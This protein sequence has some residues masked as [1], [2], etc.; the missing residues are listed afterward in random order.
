MKVA[1]RRGLSTSSA[2]WQRDRF[3]ADMLSAEELAES[4][5]SDAGSLRAV[6]SSEPAAPAVKNAR[7]VAVG[8]A[9]KSNVAQPIIGTT[10]MAAKVRPRSRPPGSELIDRTR[11]AA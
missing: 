4:M 8:K 6:R 3:G 10:S 9:A 5:S 2:V 1:T 7:A 11:R